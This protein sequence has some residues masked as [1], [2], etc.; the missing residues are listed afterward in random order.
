M[1]LDVIAVQARFDVAQTLAIGQL[2]ERHRQILI[3]ARERFDL[4][5]AVVTRHTATKRRKR[6][7]SHDLCEYR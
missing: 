3:E 1:L 7:V 4:V 5:L 2:R 6:Q